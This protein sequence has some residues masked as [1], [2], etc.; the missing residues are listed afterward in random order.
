MREFSR[1]MAEDTDKQTTDKQSLV[2]VD[3]K[4]FLRRR[5]P[6]SKRN[7][8][9]ALRTDHTHSKE[10]DDART[11]L[12]ENPIHCSWNAYQRIDN[13]ANVVLVIRAV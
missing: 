8:T 11:S 13:A 9:T 6:Q 4:R 12:R 2:T 3:L 10:L 1:K 7:H 5:R